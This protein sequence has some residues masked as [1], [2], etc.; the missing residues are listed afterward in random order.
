MPI[1]HSQQLNEVTQIL[2]VTKPDSVLDIGA[3]F[4]KYGVLA[5][6]YLELWDGREKYLDWKRRID[7]IEVFKEY[8]TPLYDFIYDNTYIGNAIEIVPKLT[9][10]YDLILLIDI[11]E[12]LD[13]KEGMQL[14]KDCLKAGHNVLVSTPKDIGHQDDKFGNPYEEHKFQWTE[15]LFQSLPHSVIIPNQASLISYIGRDAA[16]VSHLVAKK[17]KEEYR[18]SVRRLFPFLRHP[19]RLYKK[20]VAHLR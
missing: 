13:Y 5:R 17:K 14:L 4:G 6:E 1:S 9:A 2:M 10:H 15:K 3:G 18:N 19:F 7:A 16:K 8:V 11:I 12:H 20:V